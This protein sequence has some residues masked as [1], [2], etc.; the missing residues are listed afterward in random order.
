MHRFLRIIGVTR[1]EKDVIE[2]K[3]GLYSKRFKF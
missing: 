1:V 2:F 3:W